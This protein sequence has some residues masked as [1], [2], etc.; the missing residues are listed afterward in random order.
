MQPRD[1]GT[2]HY[3]QNVG[4]PTPPS[5]PRSMEG[6]MFRSGG[7]KG[8]SRAKGGGTRRVGSTWRQTT[9]ASWLSTF[10]PPGY[11][12]S[13]GPGR[14]RP[15]PQVVSAAGGGTKR[16]SRRMRCR[17]VIRVLSE[18][19]TRMLCAGSYLTRP[20]ALPDS[21]FHPDYVRVAVNKSSASKVG[22]DRAPA[23]PAGRA[24]PADTRAESAGA[25][26]SGTPGRER[27]R[28]G[29]GGGGER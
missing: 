8:A 20:N 4:W 11:S 5:C 19:K 24:G 6:W 27:V 17:A 23:L 1:S 16:I 21:P 2:P 22:A 12:H 7:S 9:V 18:S 13:A 3:P 28:W 10:V 14:D 26:S 25:C 29:R 15:V